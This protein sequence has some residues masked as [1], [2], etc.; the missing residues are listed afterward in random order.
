MSLQRAE[1]KD[2]IAREER[3]KSA[4]F[5]NNKSFSEFLAE[6]GYDLKKL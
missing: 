4:D 5:I 3:I 6:N 1:I 2:K